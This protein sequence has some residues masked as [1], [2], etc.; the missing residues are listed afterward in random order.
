MTSIL[1]PPLQRANAFDGLS[2]DPYS[3]DE[4]Q[5]ADQLDAEEGDEGGRPIVIPRGESGI[6][7]RN[8]R[9]YGGAWFG[10]NRRR[11]RRSHRR[12]SPRLPS[13]RARANA[14]HMGR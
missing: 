12:P 7:R 9:F 4:K 8:C 5:L 13:E 11:R 3:S 1:L 14:L 10:G 6:I 2:P